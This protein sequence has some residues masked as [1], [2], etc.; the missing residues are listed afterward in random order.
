MLIYGN[1]IAGSIMKSYGLQRQ[2]SILYAQTI[3]IH[4]KAGKLNSD[5]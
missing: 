3:R 1:H 4:G 5:I 2:F